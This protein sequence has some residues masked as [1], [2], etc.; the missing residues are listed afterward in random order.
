VIKIRVSY[1]GLLAACLAAGASLTTARGEP[2]TLSACA[3][4]GEDRARLACYDALSAAQSSKP[5]PM[6][7]A[8]AAAPQGAPSG[9]GVAA[10]APGSAAAPL[11][12]QDLFGYSSRRS[13]SLALGAAGLK[14][15]EQIETRISGVSVDANGK[16]VLTLKNEQVWSQV[17]STDLRIRAG[18]AVRIRR[19][20]FDSYLLSR[21]D[22]GAA[23]RVRRQR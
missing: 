8:A 23:I 12:P 10:A 17:D 6:P 5:A 1:P 16:L 19:A 4:I 13:E 22:G 3:A 20:M 18:E 14:P 15:A 9:A 11:D 2:D 21:V 7:P